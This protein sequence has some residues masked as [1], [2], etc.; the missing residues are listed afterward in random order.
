[1]KELF[2]RMSI[3]NKGIN[4]KGIQYIDIYMELI[5]TGLLASTY[6][7]LLAYKINC[8]LSG[9]RKMKDTICITVKQR[10]PGKYTVVRVAK[11]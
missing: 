6:Q 4:N 9:I 1:M 8:E 2:I 11:F 7:L 5:G 3:N 10:Q